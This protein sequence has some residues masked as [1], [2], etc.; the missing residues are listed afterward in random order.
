M[1]HGPLCS[2]LQIC[3]TIKETIHSS[4]GNCLAGPNDPQCTGRGPGP[5]HRTLAGLR[6]RLDTDGIPEILESVR[7]SVSQHKPLGL[8]GSIPIILVLPQPGRTDVIPAFNLPTTCPVTHSTLT[9]SGQGQF[10]NGIKNP[11]Q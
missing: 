8:K 10:R 3:S 7:I 4:S 11:G 2:T 1:G 6:E 5:T 9:P